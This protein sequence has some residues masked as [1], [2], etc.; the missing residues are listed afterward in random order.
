[1]QLP[2]MVYQIRTYSIVRLLALHIFNRL[3][4]SN[5]YGSQ[6]QRK[7]QHRVLDDEI[8][9]SV[10]HAKLL[11]KYMAR[12]CKNT[13]YH[14]SKDIKRNSPGKTI[15]NCNS[16]QRSFKDDINL[17]LHVYWHTCQDKKE[18]ARRKVYMFQM[19]LKKRTNQMKKIVIVVML[20]LDLKHHLDG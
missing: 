13:E 10:Q 5:V 6:G 16:C 19:I 1:M 11:T 3:L 20:N 17:M 12:S 18:T 4:A 15:H 7:Q 2:D 9:N 14:K 8:I